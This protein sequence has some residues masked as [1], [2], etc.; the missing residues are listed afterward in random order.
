M[1]YQDEDYDVWATD[2]EDEFRCLLDDL[3]GA[4]S[5]HLKNIYGRKLVAWVKNLVKE[6][7]DYDT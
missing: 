2:I 1:T 6:A 3:M 7:G 4:P 5:G